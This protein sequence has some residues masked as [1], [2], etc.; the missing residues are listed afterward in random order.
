VFLKKMQK[1]SHVTRKEFDIAMRLIGINPQEDKYV[2]SLGMS[3]VVDPSKLANET[4]EGM[5]DV[6]KN[7]FKN[8]N[9]MVLRRFL[10]AIALGPAFTK[11]NDNPHEEA[12]VETAE[13]DLDE[14]EEEE[15]Q[16]PIVEHNIPVLFQ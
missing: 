14:I 9:R 2:R 3:D 12:P 10:D 4:V 5:V 15:C 1:F 13:I 8:G 16:T 11:D 6:L 7:D